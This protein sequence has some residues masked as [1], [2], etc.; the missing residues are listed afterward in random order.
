LKREIIKL[1]NEL[2][3][4]AIGLIPEATDRKPKCLIVVV[5]V[6]IAIVVIQVAVPGIVCIV[7]SRT[8]PV[9]VLANVVECSIVVT[10]TAWKT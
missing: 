8:P 7:L 2:S 5:P 6:Y 9:T 10:V 3:P 1:S 4:I